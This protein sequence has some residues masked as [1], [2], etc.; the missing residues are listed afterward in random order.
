MEKEKSLKLTMTRRLGRSQWVVLCTIRD[1][2]DPKL[3]HRVAWS[4][5]DFYACSCS[6]WVFSRTVCAHLERLGPDMLDVLLESALAN[7]L[8]PK[9]PA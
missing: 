4:S 3:Q 1:D 8:G 5:H 7:L 9:V 6:G 2:E